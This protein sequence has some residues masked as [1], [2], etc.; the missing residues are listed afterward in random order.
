MDVF[1]AMDTCIAMRYLKPD[2][3]PRADLER[4]VHYATRASSPSN[5][6]F[7]SFIVVTDPEVRKRLGQ[8]VLSMTES[9]RAMAG[10]D[11]VDAS[12]SKMYAGAMHLI[13]NFARVPAWIVCCGRHA[14]PAENPLESMLYGAV[15]PAAQNLIVAA[16]AMG[17]GTTFTTLQMMAE[18]QF[19]EILRIPE[20]V[21]PVVTVAVGYPE[22]AF[23]KNTRK[24]LAEVLHWNGW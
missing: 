18:P 8:A 24:P 2:P 16:R 4:L 10:T 13:E 15:Y 9:L 14:Y 17:L 23:R 11:A 3:V 22:R 6:Q 20:G 7:W 12:R 1:E 21:R 5:S 19:R